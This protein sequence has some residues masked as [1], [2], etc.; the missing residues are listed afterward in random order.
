MTRPRDRMPISVYRFLSEYHYLRTRKRNKR[1]YP[2]ITSG[3]IRLFCISRQSR[4]KVIW[5]KKQILR[6]VHKT[7][8]D[9]THTSTLSTPLFVSLRSNDRIA[10]L[11]LRDS[12]GP[13]HQ[14]YSTYGAS[15]T[16]MLLVAQ[17]WLSKTELPKKSAAGCPKT[18]PFHQL[19]PF[20]VADCYFFGK[21]IWVSNSN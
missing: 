12:H 21:R 9:E 16:K 19:S 6:L 18:L 15:K 14:V 17:D 11:T 2:G 10:D 5:L 13:L 20:L 3:G 1:I 7:E 8:V 4:K